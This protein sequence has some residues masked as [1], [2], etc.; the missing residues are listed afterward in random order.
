[1]ERGREIGKGA[2]EK[3]STGEYWGKRKWELDREKT[4]LIKHCDKKVYKQSEKRQ[5]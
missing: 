5:R 1:M 4:C 3:V 2:S